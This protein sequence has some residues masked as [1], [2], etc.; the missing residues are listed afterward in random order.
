[1]QKRI[2]PKGMYL[3]VDMYSDPYYLAEELVKKSIKVSMSRPKL[4]SRNAEAW[5]RVEDKL[6]ST[7]DMTSDTNIISIELYTKIFRLFWRM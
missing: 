6:S 5:K 2:N 3:M 1:M 7:I 4:S